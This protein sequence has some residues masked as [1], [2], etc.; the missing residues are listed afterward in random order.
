MNDIKTMV[1][2]GKK[3]YFVSY[4]N[5]NFIYRTECGF[6]FFVPLSE[7]VGGEF[8]AEDRAMFFMRHIRK[9]MK[10]IEQE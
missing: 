2:N 7:T 6:E 4:K 8:L 5:E 10:F 1:G 9:H 3:V